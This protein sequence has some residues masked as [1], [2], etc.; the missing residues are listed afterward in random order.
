ME[1]LPSEFGYRGR[2]L[3]MTTLVRTLSL[4]LALLLF[5][6]KG[7]SMPTVPLGP[8]R[9]SKLGAL[10][11]GNKLTLAPSGITISIPND[12]L[13]W[14]EKFNNN[15]HLSSSDM[16]KVCHGIGE[17]DTEYSQIINDMFPFPRCVAHIG[18]EGW[19]ADGVSF[20]DI[21]MRIYH[22]ESNSDQVQLRIETLAPG[23]VEPLVDDEHSTLGPK[24]T[25]G[26]IESIDGWK[27]LLIRFGRFY[28]DYGDTANVDVRFRSFNSE[29]IVV[30][31]MYADRSHISG[32]IDG[33]ING[34]IGF[35]QG[36]GR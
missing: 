5:G 35:P 2:S 21:Q 17:W 10:L 8:Q 1:D 13:E 32:E 16:R 33:L 22:L 11:S 14:N 26:S 6:C 31:L 19:G 3:P 7:E 36:I 18:G 29:T 30:V 25:I 24:P 15:F 27:R 4:L 12:W 23:A 20:G 34:I 28:Y 9:D